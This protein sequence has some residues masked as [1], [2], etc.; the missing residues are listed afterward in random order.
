LLDVMR[1]FSQQAVHVKAH[2]VISSGWGAKVESLLA[3]VSAAVEPNST[4]R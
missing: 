1:T 3:G 4:A 2:M